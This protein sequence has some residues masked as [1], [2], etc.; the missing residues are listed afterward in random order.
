MGIKSLFSCSTIWALV[1]L[2]SANAIAA[3]HLPSDEDVNGILKLCAVGRVQKFEGDLK[4]KID[5]WKRGA[6]ATGNASIEDLGALFQTIKPDPSSVELYKTYTSCVKDNIGQYLNSRSS[7]LDRDTILKIIDINKYRSYLESKLGP[8]AYIDSSYQNGIIE[9]G[10]RWRDL[11]LEIFYLKD[12]SIQYIVTITNRLYKPGI[13]ELC[14][15]VDSAN[16]ACI[17]CEVFAKYNGEPYYAGESSKF[18]DY[19]EMLYVG[20]TSDGDKTMFLGYTSYGAD[21]GNDPNASQGLF[22]I[23]NAIAKKRNG[24]ADKTDLRALNIIKR[25]TYPNSFTVRYDLIPDKTFEDIPLVEEF[26]ASRLMPT[27]P[28]P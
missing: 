27:S 4:G 1:A 18:F 5:F 9:A 8:P 16:N 3:E 14:L 23:G 6:E 13:R 12:M 21:Y 22:V 15:C 24:T 25:G 28:D 11:D 26:V 10:Y 2:L 20:S 17:G 7:M 19:V